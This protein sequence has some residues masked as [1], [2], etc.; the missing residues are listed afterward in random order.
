MNFVVFA[1]VNS[2]KQ[3]SCEQV[4]RMFG[5]ISRILILSC[6]V[7]E[8]C[9]SSASYLHSLPSKH[10][11]ANLFCAGSDIEASLKGLAERRTDIFGVE[12]TAIGKKV[13]EEDQPSD[14]VVRR[15]RFEAGQQPVRGGQGDCPPRNFQTV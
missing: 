5:R 2:S 14:E 7:H 11:S 12:E 1:F 3:K 4:G 15:A 10:E 8:A 9:G 6:A 13:G